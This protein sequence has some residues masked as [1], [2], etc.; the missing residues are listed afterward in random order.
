MPEETIK[1]RGREQDLAMTQAICR[2][3]GSTFQTEGELRDHQPYCKD[4]G[5]CLCHIDRVFYNA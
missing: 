4:P 2:A 1:Q 3:C 5:F